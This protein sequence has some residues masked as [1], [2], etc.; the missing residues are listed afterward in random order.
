MDEAGKRLQAIIDT[1]ID[2]IITIDTLGVIESINPAGAL[3]FGYEMEDLIGQKINMLMPQPHRSQHDQ[4]LTNY[5]TTR[6]PKIIGIGR[7]V[8]GLRKDGST[9]PLRLAVS[10]VQLDNRTLFTGI[11]HDLSAMK[12]AERSLKELN[13]KLETLVDDRTRELEEVINKLLKV[14]EQLEYEISERKQMQEILQQREEQLQISLAKEMELG[15]LKSRFVSMASHEFRTP[16]ST[17]LSS[18]ALLQRYTLEEH[19]DRRDKH[20]SRI[21]SSVANLTGI[22]NDFLSLSKLE[23]GKI[24]VNYQRITLSELCGEVVD[25]VQGLLKEGQH[26]YLED[27]TSGKEVELD[28]RIMKNILFNLLS[29]AIKYSG[30]DK[31]IHCIAEF[32]E[33]NLCV[34]IRDRGIGIPLAEQKH[35]FSRFFRATNSLNIQ[36][37]GLGLDIVNRYLKLLNGTITF[38]SEEG[39]GSSF[40]ITIPQ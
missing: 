18:A 12:A 19:Q 13:D 17:I 15:E 34:T 6:E 27:R 25:E 22:L 36:G 32:E 16:L 38:E 3:L 24:E 14:N 9:F 35:L 4:Y 1:V 39:E 37:T 20:I 30:E 8:E 5:L 29:N 31:P 33:S 28:R 21:K 26:I 10:E 40:T 23:E 7:E 2:G 11:I